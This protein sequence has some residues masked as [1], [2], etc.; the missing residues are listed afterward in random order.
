MRKLLLIPL[1]MLLCI[2]CSAQATQLKLTHANGQEVIFDLRDNPVITFH[3]GD[4]R[5]ESDDDSVEMPLDD[6]RLEYVDDGSFTDIQSPENAQSQFEDG[7]IVFQGLHAK[8]R[9]SI[10]TLDGKV[11]STLHADGNGRQT[12][13][14]S[15][16]KTGAYIIKAGKFAI[17]FIKK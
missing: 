10:V 6:T 3:D 1:F 13:D 12:I 7:R 11:V 5:I 8:Q 14:T 15:R 9:I 17:K 4:I 16:L 2:P